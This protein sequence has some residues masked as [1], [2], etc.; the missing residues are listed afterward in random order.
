[1][2]VRSRK[3]HRIIATLGHRLAWLVERAAKEVIMVLRVWS[4]FAFNCGMSTGSLL[5]V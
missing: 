5:Y 2:A 4:Q 3:R 1:M